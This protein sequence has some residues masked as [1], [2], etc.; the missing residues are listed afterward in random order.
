MADVEG[1]ELEEG[2]V[3]TSDEEEGDQGE[4]E[5]GEGA[6]GTHALEK[7]E[8]KAQEEGPVA[9]TKQPALDSEI[10]NPK[11]YTLYRSV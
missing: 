10:P 2:E 3:L 5:G 4:G 9:G 1:G 7:T 11:V 8:E 6:E